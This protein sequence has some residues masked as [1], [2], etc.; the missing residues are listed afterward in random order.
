MRVTQDR[1]ILALAPSRS[2]PS[3]CRYSVITGL[4]DNGAIQVNEGVLRGLDYALDQARQ[5]G[6]RVILVF[7]DYFADGAGGPLQY[8]QLAGAGSADPQTLKAEFYTNAAAQAIFKQYVALVR[9]RAGGSVCMLV[10]M[11]E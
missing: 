5:N 1:A 8:M 11:Q 6:V 7:T 3:P 4:G 10:V 9:A 2:V